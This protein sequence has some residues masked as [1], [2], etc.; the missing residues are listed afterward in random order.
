MLIIVSGPPG[1]G[2]STVAAL[3]AKKFPQSAQFS[4]DT[5]RHFVKGSNIPPWEK[6]EKAERQLELAE[7]IVRDITKRYIDNGYVVI[8]DGV[9]FDEHI[10]KYQDSFKEIFGFILL[11]SVEKLKE[12]DTYREQ[13]KQ[14][15]HRIEPLHAAFS[16]QENKLFE[17]IDTSN[18][19]TEETVEYI[20]QRI[21]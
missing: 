18:Q 9:Y 12:R 2:K 16:T 20:F 19:T 17:V 1:A 14:M 21:S 3:L 15:P 11:P 4:N 10:E 7:D 5:I 13:D 8:I 6:G